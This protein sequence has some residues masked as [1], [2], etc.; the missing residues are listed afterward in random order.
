MTNVSAPDWVTQ[1]GALFRPGLGNS[2]YVLFN[3]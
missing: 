2:W 3:D 1:R